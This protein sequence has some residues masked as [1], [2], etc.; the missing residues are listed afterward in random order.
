MG[1]TN[2]VGVEVIEIARFSTAAGKIIAVD[3][4]NLAVF[5]GVAVNIRV[6]ADKLAL[7]EIPELWLDSHDAQ[8]ADIPATGLLGVSGPARVQLGRFERQV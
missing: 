1:R 5:M 3:R 6:A 8:D 4:V 7:A 2:G